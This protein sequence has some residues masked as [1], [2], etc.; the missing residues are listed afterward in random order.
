MN[1]DILP[2]SGIIDRRILDVAIQRMREEPVIALQGARAV[3]KSTLLS[4]LAERSDGEVIDLDEPAMRA[5]VAADPGSFLTGHSPVCIDEHQHVP[6]VLDAIKA[7]LNR[8]SRPGRFVITGSTRYDAPPT[9]AQ[10]LTGRLDVLTV[11]PLAWREIVDF[12]GSLLRALME[13]PENA[14]SFGSIS[15]TTREQHATRI[16]AGGMPI[17]LRRATQTGRNRWFDN[18]L[19]LI[20]ERDLRDI[21]RLRLVEQIPG[22]LRRLAAQ[23]AQPLNMTAIANDAGIDR[24]T[25][26]SHLKP[27]EAVFLVTRLPA[28]GMTLRRRAANAPKVHIVDS[29]LASRLLRLTPEKLAARDPASL[30]QFGHLLETFVVGELCR[31]AS[32]LEGIAALG[33]WRT[34]DGQEVDLIVERDDG[35]VLAFE[36]KA[37]RQVTKADARHLLRLRKTLGERLLAGVVLCMGPRSYRLDDRIHV[38][39]IDRLWQAA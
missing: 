34:H 21:S 16:A 10:S 17:P 6:G 9:A 24:T 2:I 5:A 13:D 4:A 36:V 32:W 7:E 3:G 11:S 1:T 31:E 23:T 8:D 39:P 38:L 18:Y 15:K 14:V 35:A 30:S 25:A 20:L 26:A 27:L 12:E 19:T 28:W 37:G 29:G 22:L 33:H